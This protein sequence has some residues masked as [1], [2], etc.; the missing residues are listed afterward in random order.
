MLIGEKGDL[1]LV[2][3]KR[4]ATVLFELVVSYQWSKKKEIR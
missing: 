1:F 2:R 3:N 4:N